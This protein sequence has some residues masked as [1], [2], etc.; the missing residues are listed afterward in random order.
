MIG[1]W[2][3][4]SKSYINLLQFV[5]TVARL[6]NSASYSLRGSSHMAFVLAAFPEQLFKAQGAV[7]EGC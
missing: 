5:G 1:K 6:E 4:L 7:P 3:S 2:G